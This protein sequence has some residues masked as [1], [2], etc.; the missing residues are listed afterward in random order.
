MIENLIK[1]NIKYLLYTP[2]ILKNLGYNNYVKEY[3]N[4]GLVS[5][6]PNA[7]CYKY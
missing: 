5:A 4:S 7:I 1:N 6:N 3:S 2:R